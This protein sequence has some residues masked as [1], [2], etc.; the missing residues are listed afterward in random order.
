[1]VVRVSRLI[2]AP[3]ELVFDLYTNPER[4]REW[5]PGLRGT[6]AARGRLDTP[7][8]TYVP[9]QPGP[10]L[11]ITVIAVVRPHVHEQR[12]SFALFGWILRAHFV[13]EGPSTRV[14]FEY[15]YGR[16]L[17]PLWTWIMRALASTYGRTELDGIKAV[18]E[19][20][21]KGSEP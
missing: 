8:S 6:V 18:A 11:T 5:Q 16:G 12:A 9:D 17:R 20:D 19:R 15:R 2:A 7:G 10:R 3:P 14:V 13:P 1:M 4:L 21:A